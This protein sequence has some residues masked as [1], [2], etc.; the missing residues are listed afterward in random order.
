MKNKKFKVLIYL[1]I[2][3]FFSSNL[4]STEIFNFEFNDIEITQNGN[5]FRGYNGGKILSEDEI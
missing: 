5:F 3:L 4:Y 2:N 1:F